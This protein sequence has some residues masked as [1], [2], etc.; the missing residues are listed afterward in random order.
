M[1]ENELV[2]KELQR[3]IGL[4]L[5]RRKKRLGWFRLIFDPVIL[6]YHHLLFAIINTIIYAASSHRFGIFAAETTNTYVIPAFLTESNF[7]SVVNSPTVVFLDVAFAAIGFPL[8]CDIMIDILGY[9][10][11]EIKDQENVSFITIAEKAKEWCL[12]S[13]FIVA[14]AV[15]SMVR[16]C[17]PTDNRKIVLVY[18][19]QF[20]RTISMV[21]FGMFSY[22][23][24]CDQIGWEYLRSFGISMA[25]SIGQ[26]MVYFASL[27]EQTPTMYAISST[28]KVLCILTSCYM[29]SLFV[30]QLYSM[31]QRVVKPGGLTNLCT[32]ELCFVVHISLITINCCIITMMLVAS[33]CELYRMTLSMYVTHA[34]LLL[35][36]SIA[37]T[38]L[39]V[40]ICWYDARRTKGS[41]I[42]STRRKVENTLDSTLRCLMT[43]MDCL[44]HSVN[45]YQNLSQDE[46]L[47]L[48]RIVSL[49]SDVSGD[50]PV[51]WYIMLPMF[52]LMSSSLSYLIS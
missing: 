52:T 26:F 16:V 4:V 10:M 14:F 47:S 44:L 32:K 9:Y 17:G 30:Y 13:Q 43:E 22:T 28:G 51:C 21:I 20:L 34:V 35:F 7:L 29:C 33:G 40:R 31:F 27:V 36:S 25:L 11:A 45:F 1:R 12:R 39:P 2:Y 38:S 18:L 15:T 42:R 5:A 23:D 6:P 24:T 48:E 8:I 50:L 3:E 41:I 37:L 49:C 46:L 19:T